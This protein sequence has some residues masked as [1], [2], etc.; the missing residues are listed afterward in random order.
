M[1]NFNGVNPGQ[2]N[3]YEFTRDLF[4]WDGEFT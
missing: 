2:K 3:Y 1:L 4:F